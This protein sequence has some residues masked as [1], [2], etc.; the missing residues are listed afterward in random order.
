MAEYLGLNKLRH[1][2]STETGGSSY[3]IHL[4]HAAQAIAAGHC[5]VALITLADRPVAAAAG[6]NLAGFDRSAIPTCPTARV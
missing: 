5:N 4:R 2:D 6:T 1:I 3:L